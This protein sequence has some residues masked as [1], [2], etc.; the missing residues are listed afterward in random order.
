MSASTKA[1]AAGF[2]SR[3]ASASFSP[4]TNKRWASA[5]L[6]GAAH[7]TVSCD[8]A[9][10]QLKTLRVSVGWYHISFWERKSIS[11]FMV[12]EGRFAPVAGMKSKPDSFRSATGTPVLQMLAFAR[13]V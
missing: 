5:M 12:T 13:K 10:N 9:A 3:S 11:M 8:T 2:S 6:A 4:H 7:D 1:K